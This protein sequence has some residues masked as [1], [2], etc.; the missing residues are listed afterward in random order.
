MTTSSS[1]AAH[2]RMTSVSVSDLHD[3]VSNLSLHGTE[4][5]S[6]M[7]SLPKTFDSK[8]VKLEE[9]GRGGFSYVY[10]CQDI[11]TKVIYAVK[12]IDLRP[13]R[14]RDKFDPNRLRREVEIMKNLRHKNIVQF[15]E[16]FESKDEFYMVLEYCPGRELFDVILANQK[17][18]EAE[19]LPIFYQV[20]LSSFPFHK[21]KSTE[22]IL[23]LF[24]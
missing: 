9:I 6:K 22:F 15:I 12:I 20:N 16:Y 4:S 17:L 23:Y 5:A 8:Y 7:R 3:S 24:S 21:F 14:L 13:F 18:S 10:R 11:A 2:K 1:L 19:A